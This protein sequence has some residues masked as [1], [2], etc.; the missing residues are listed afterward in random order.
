MFSASSTPAHLKVLRLY[1]GFTHRHFPE[2]AIIEAV[3]T[4]I[5]VL[6]LAC[7][8][9][10]RVDASVVQARLSSLLGTGTTASTATADADDS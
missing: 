7:E 1:P 5:A 8:S 9:V 10:L 3:K 6:P 4:F 2:D